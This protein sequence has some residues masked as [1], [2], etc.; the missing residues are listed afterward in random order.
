MWG[1]SLIL[2]NGDCLEKLKELTDCSVD[3]LV[4][5][6][7]AGISFMGSGSTGL[8]AKECGFE[9]IG[10][11]KEKEYFEIAKAIINADKF[12][13]KGCEWQNV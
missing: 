4:T 12:T 6:P 7:P 1:D 3:S 5:D 11:E 9:F 10:I 13:Q 8:A 2:L